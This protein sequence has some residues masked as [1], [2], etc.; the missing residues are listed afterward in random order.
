MKNYILYFIY[1]LIFLW[2]GFLFLHVYNLYLLITQNIP[3]CMLSSS[4]YF[5]NIL[6]II[7]FM[8]SCCFILISIISIKNCFKL[9]QKKIN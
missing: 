6:R 8:M 4:V 1:F 2:T 7:S 5:D 9:L 3:E